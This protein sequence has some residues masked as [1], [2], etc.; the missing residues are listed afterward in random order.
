MKQLKYTVRFNTPA[1][2]GDAEQSGRWRTPPFKALLRQW[3]RVVVAKNFGYD[4]RRMREAE[5][6]LFGNAWL[7]GDF[8]K[9]RIR[10]RLD[11]WD[12]G[13]L[14]KD[15][16]QSLATVH[17]PDVKVP[18]GSDLYLGYGP[19]MPPGRGAKKTSLKANAAIQSDETAE[20]SLALPDKDAGYVEAAMA[21]M[22]AYGTLG[23]RSR[24]GW[25]SISL[26]PLPQGEGRGEGDQH[27]RLPNSAFRTWQEALELD[28]PHAIGTDDEGPLIWQTQPIDDWKPL[29]KLL[30]E[31]KIGLRTQ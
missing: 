30:A 8:S 4:H 9:S 23:G 6:R 15:R 16:W 3:W 1:F 26:L 24:N 17:H 29:M 7:E 18:V 19:V 20:L 28:W 2:L 21:L 12:E 14:K 13:K 31:I 22:N 27:A 11:R 10:M 5:G 25:G